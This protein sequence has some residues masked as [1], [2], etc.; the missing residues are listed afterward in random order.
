MAAHFNYLAEEFA[1]GDRW[2]KSNPLRGVWWN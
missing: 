2:L 1:Q